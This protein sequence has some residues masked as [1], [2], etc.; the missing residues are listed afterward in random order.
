MWSLL[1]CRREVLLGNSQC[2]FAGVG[3]PQ[4]VVQVFSQRSSR[5]RALNH[6]PFHLLEFHTF[7]LIMTSCSDVVPSTGQPRPGI[8]SSGLWER[9]IPFNYSREDLF[10]CTLALLPSMYAFVHQPLP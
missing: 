9:N 6:L 5:C 10:E 4:S 8:S 2:S 1:V 7:P 3:F